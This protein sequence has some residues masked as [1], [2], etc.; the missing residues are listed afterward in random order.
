MGE[1]RKKG[2]IQKY[3]MYFTAVI[4]IGCVILAA[5]YYIRYIQDCLMVQTLSNVQ[6]VTQQHQQAFDNFISRDLERVHSYAENF[7]TLDSGDVEAIQSKL[8]VFFDAGALYNVVNLDTGEYYVSKSHDILQ[9]SRK[10]QE[11]LSGY[12]DKGVRESYISIYTGTQMFG[13]YERFTFRDGAKGI[14]QK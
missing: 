12:P 11:S 8:D 10:A 1:K 7:A 13:Y 6:T 5:Y 9:L 4:S 3:W 14:I 2:Y